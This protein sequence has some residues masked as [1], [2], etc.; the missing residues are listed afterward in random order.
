MV[1]ARILAIGADF[2]PVGGVKP[3]IFRPHTLAMDLA[4]AFFCKLL[5]CICPWS[6]LP[7][8]VIDCRSWVGFVEATGLF[9]CR[10]VQMS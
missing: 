6:W 2:V 9:F 5:R 1:K 10:L 3:F 7:I 4:F 8:S